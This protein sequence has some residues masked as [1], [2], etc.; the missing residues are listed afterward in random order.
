MT[1]LFDEIDEAS[2]PNWLAGNVDLSQSNDTEEHEMSDFQK[3]LFQAQKD[4]LRSDRFRPN[5]CFDTFIQFGGEILE[6]IKTIVDHADQLE[7]DLFMESHMEFRYQD[8]LIHCVIKSEFG[9][10]WD[11]E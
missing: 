3:T 11:D 5:F 10:D 8:A 4:H 7:R 9:G 1:K 2:A 6:L